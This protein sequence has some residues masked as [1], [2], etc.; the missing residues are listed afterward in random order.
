MGPRCDLTFLETASFSTLI[1][2]SYDGAL[3]V[4]GVPP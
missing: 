1:G 4:H 3:S 2:R